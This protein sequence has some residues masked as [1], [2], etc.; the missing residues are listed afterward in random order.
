MRNVGPKKKVPKF[1]Y[2]KRPT[3]EKYQSRKKD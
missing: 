1:A 2:R 3:T